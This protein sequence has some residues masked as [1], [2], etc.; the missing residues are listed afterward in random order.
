MRKLA[1]FLLILLLG[2]SFLTFG[3]PTAREA[4]ASSPPVPLS[5]LR[6]ANYNPYPLC[7]CGI[8]TANPSPSTAF[9]EMESNGWNYAK[10]YLS[11]GEILSDSSYLSTL[12]S[13]ASNAASNGIY[14]IYTLGA[15]AG[16][17]NSPDNNFWPSAI[18][19][20]YGGC[21]TSQFWQA[22]LTDGITDGGQS[23]WNAE[24][25][26]F[27]TP[28]INQIDSSSSTYGYEIINEPEQ[29]SGVTNAQ[30]QAYFQ[31]F[32]N[33]LQSNIASNHMILFEG[34]CPSACGYSTNTADAEAQ[35]PTGISNLAIDEHNYAD[36]STSSASANVAA[37]SSYFSAYNSIST[38]LGIPVLI[39]EWGVCGISSP[40][41]CKI[42]TNSWAQTI[43]QGYEQYFHQYG[44]ANSYWQL[45]CANGWYD[46]LTTGCTQ[47]TLSSYIVQYQGPTST[48]LVTLSCSP[49][50]ITQ[51]SGS[52]TTTCTTT[53][54]GT[55]PTGTVS[56]ATTSSTGVFS[57]T[58][59][60]LSSGSCS[61]TYYDTSPGVP[62]ITATYSGDSNN[63]GGTQTF[64]V[65]VTSTGGGGSSNAGIDGYASNSCPGVTTSCSATLTAPTAGD[66][67][68]AWTASANGQ[69]S[70]SAPTGT[71][72]SWSSVVT[73]NGG[74]GGV[75]GALYEA[76]AAGSLSGQTVTCNEGTS[77]HMNCVVIAVKGATGTFDGSAVS[78]SSLSSSSPSVSITTTNANDMV[79]NF[80]SFGD[81]PTLNSLPSGFSQVAAQGSDPT[82]PSTSKIFT[83]T[84]SSLAMTYA[85]SASKPWVE[86]GV[87]IEVTATTSTQMFLTIALNM[88]SNYYVT[89]EYATLSGCVSPSV[90]IPVGYSYNTG[91]SNPS[92]TCTLTL[93]PDNTTSRWLTNSSTTSF[94]FTGGSSILLFYAFYQLNIPFSY[95]VQ[96]GNNTLPSTPDIYLTELGTPGVVYPLSVLTQY[97]FYDAGTMPNNTLAISNGPDEQWYNFTNWV[98]APLSTSEDFNIVYQH[99][100]YL[101]MTSTGQGTALP[102]SMWAA[103]G[104]AIQI[105][106]TP[107]NGQSFYGW[108]GTGTGSYTGPSEIAMIINDPVTEGAFFTQPTSEIS[109]SV[110]YAGTDLLG[111]FIAFNPTFTYY[112]NGVAESGTLTPTPTTYSVDNNS[113]LFAE[114]SWYNNGQVM[115]PTPGGAP[116]N[117]SGSSVIFAYSAPSLASVCSAA[118]TNTTALFQNQCASPA[119]IYTYGN[120]VTLPTFYAFCLAICVL[121]IYQDKK[122]ILLALYVALIAGGAIVSAVGILDIRIE[123]LVW[124]GIVMTT[125]FIFVRLYKGRAA[126]NT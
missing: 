36:Y 63:Q 2:F 81:S 13:I 107:N 86:V 108:V 53:V 33:K 77:D 99:Q 74:G 70:F 19:N 7:A 41:T 8:G 103:A 34:G 49:S 105:T 106:A 15:L 12:S 121:P 67:I 30:M 126:G 125:A 97:Y 94:S 54:T 21:P 5:H 64:S 90:P 61:V 6:G 59:C 82:A 120:E 88:P 116:V 29:G 100:F 18:T 16:A 124:V 27:W 119:I 76:T 80:G 25:S 11:W 60:T 71:S 89:G 51:S 73:K 110:S 91:V 32:A 111:G 45:G 78:A 37:A 72:L 62:K 47:N 114:N 56:Y 3:F 98:Y 52:S 118:G 14:V 122:N 85:L 96:G 66:L 57:S 1:F 20:S 17:C 109:V 39:G 115:H 101:N 48:T 28:V 35:A 55:S 26:Q 50:S 113:V 38:S 112:Q 117:K 95:T 44:F 4:S 9:S 93:P 69:T 22:Y 123:L 75:S 65:T 102:G 42:T 24:W 23:V 10:V 58:S 46:L 84:Q 83:T 43:V 40:G 104:A 87:A 92:G 31:F 68:L 79:L